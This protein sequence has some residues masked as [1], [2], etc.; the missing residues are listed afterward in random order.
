METKIQFRVAPSTP[1]L[2]QIRAAQASAK[3]NRKEAFA[4]LNALFRAG[5]PPVPP[6]DGR[7]RGELV[8]LDVAPGLTQFA[9]TIAGAWMPWQGK[10]FDAARG[11][12]DN[13]FARDSLALAHIFWP[14]YRGYADDTPNTYRAFAF[15]TYLAPGKTDPDRTV[16]K[17]D[18]DS[19]SNPGAT[20][21]R[22]LDELVQVADELYFGKAHLHWWSGKW[23]TVAYF[24]LAETR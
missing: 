1:I 8:A 18:Y 23:Q 9:E 14:L 13:V 10:T 16:L 15:R 2:D 5:K 22:V 20:V 21:R 24:T 19:K 6:L 11:A 12:G 7:Y 17:I 3:R 4:A